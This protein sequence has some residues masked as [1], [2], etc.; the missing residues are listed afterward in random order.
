M[1]Q[2]QPLLARPRRQVAQGTN[3]PLARIRLNDTLR[4]L[5]ATITET[6]AEAERSAARLQYEDALNMW[7]RVLEL[8]EQGDPRAARAR[9]GIDEARSHMAR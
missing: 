7:E 6:I 1:R 4:E 8:T 5:D 2:L 9:L 3:H